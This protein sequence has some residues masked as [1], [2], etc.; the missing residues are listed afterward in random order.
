MEHTTWKWFFIRRFLLILALVSL[1]E[2]LLNLWYSSVVYPWMDKTL[3]VSF[4]MADGEGGQTIG[5]LLRGVAFLAV[6]GI[7]SQFPGIAGVGL[8]GFAEQF[9]G[10]TLSGL[11]QDQTSHMSE[12]EAKI[13]FLGMAL[14]SILVVFTLLLPYAIAAVAFSHMVELHVRQ[15]EEQERRQREEYGRR[16]NLLLSDV[17]HDLKTPMTTVA[18]YAKALL[19]EPDAPRQEYLEAVYSKSMQMSGLL[20]LLFEYVK[21]DSEGYRLQKTEEDLW[22]LL[23]ECIAALYM[24]FEAKEMGLFLEIP[25][26]EARMLVDKVQFQRVATNLLNNA[27]RHNPRGT[28]VLVTAECDGEPACI[29]ICDDGPPIPEGTAAYIFDPFVSGDESRRSKG[30]SGLGLSIAYKIIAMHGGSLSLDQGLSGHWTKS[31]NIILDPS[32]DKGSL[33]SVK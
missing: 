12:Q 24:E 4:F 21:L 5:M 2:A 1:S 6:M 27:I 30:G 22:E 14:F 9:A 3:H 29:R 15:L 28:Q 7:C 13:Y 10:N 19:E 32:V 11:I 25:E 26:G 17:A 33:H 20:N 8:Q 31:F 16:R 18:G 23:R